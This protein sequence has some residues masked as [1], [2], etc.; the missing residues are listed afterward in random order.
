MQF[1]F[2]LAEQRALDFFAND[3]SKI[4]IVLST[5]RSDKSVSSTSKTKQVLGS[6]NNF[7]QKMRYL[8]LFFSLF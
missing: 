2:K 8:T 4:Q 1:L 6:L 5:F 3:F 7:D